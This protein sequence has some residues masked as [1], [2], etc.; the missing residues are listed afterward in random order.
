MIKK[1]DVKIDEGTIKVIESFIEAKLPQ[2]YKEFL[3]KYN[4]GTPYKGVFQLNHITSG[5]A[6]FYI[7]NSVNYY[8][9][10]VSIYHTLKDRI[11]KGFIIIASD[12][13]GNGILL[14]LENEN[15]GK[16][17]FWD[18]EEEVEDDEEPDFRNMT[19]LSKSFTEFVD[20]LVVDIEE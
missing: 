20:S 16:I 4:G 6:F 1:H 5:L 7:V 14:G 10:F 9:D 18:H 2:D 12:V 19:F 13:G 15:R 8:S 11:P 17:Y 3:L